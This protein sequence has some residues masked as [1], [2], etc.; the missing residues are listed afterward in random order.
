MSTTL[1]ELFDQSVGFLSS[2]NLYYGHGVET[3]EDE[4]LL[5]LMFVLDMDYA[6][7]NTQPDYE[8]HPEQKLQAE[9]LLRKRVEQRIPMAYV[10]GFSVFAG[11]RF[12]VDHRVLIPRS[13]FAELIDL[14]FNPWIG[15]ETATTVLDLC[16]GSGCIGLA[17]AH[18]FEQAQVDV[19]DISSD[20]LELA[21]TNKR[22]LG[23]G[24]NVSVIESDLFAEISG[25][26]DL[27][28]SN[29]PYVDEEEFAALPDEYTYEPKQALVSDR[30]GMEIPVKILFE[31]P[32]H[33]SEQGFLFLEVGYNDEVLEDF[34][35]DISFEW[36]HLSMGGQGIC[37]FSREDLLK[38]NPLFKSFL[39]DNVT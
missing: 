35:P 29:P 26:Y 11:L 8:V 12:K 30:S 5:L 31:A 1:R 13:P 16:T 38:Y 9:N 2:R 3:A 22:L 27:I 7:F 37:V 18:Y 19:S 23:L 15:F 21:K 25:Q 6:T 4:V 14:G 34:F 20:A 39:Q 32:N 28:V 24:A 10:V 33:L 36:V 17:I